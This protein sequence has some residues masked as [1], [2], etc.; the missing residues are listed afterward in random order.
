MSE[1]Q[2]ANETTSTIVL[3]VD[4]H[5]FDKDKVK[6][7]VKDSV[8]KDIKLKKVAGDT[9]SDELEYDLSNGNLAATFIAV[10][11]SRADGDLVSGKLTI[12]ITPKR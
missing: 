5:Q 1:P 3:N 11:D 6:I 12:T 8:N 9:P 10:E 2:K 7:S 4:G